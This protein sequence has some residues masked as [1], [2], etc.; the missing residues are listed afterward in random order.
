MPV[1]ASLVSTALPPKL[2]TAASE[3]FRA[4]GGSFA[5]WN[6]ED[7]ATMADALSRLEDRLELQWIDSIK[8]GKR[9]ALYALRMAVRE[10]R[11]TLE[12]DSQN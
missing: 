2:Y 11:R 6:R 3:D 12:I 5:R 10:V 7:E 8:S 9:D 4:H 1:S